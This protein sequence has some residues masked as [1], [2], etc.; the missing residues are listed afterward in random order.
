MLDRKVS[1]IIY[2]IQVKDL[3]FELINDFFEVCILRNLFDIFK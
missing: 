2:L 3:Q 1:L